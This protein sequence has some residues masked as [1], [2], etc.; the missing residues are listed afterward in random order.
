MTASND[1]AMERAHAFVRSLSGNSLL[2][3]LPGELVG[4]LIERLSAE[5][6]AEFRALERDVLERAAADVSHKAFLCHTH[7]ARG[8]G[9]ERGLLDAAKFLEEKAAAILTLGEEPASTMED[10]TK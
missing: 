2:L 5:F 9:R 10:E 8:V 7:D 4:Q 1:R 6:A 3:A